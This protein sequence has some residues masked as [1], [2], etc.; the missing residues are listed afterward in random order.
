[1]QSE[2]ELNEIAK[3]AY[4]DFTDNYN[5]LVAKTGRT[6]FTIEEL[7]Y[8]NTTDDQTDKE[9]Q[10]IVKAFCQ[11]NNANITYDREGNIKRLNMD[12]VYMTPNEL[13]TWK[14]VAVNDCNSKNGFYGYAVATS[15]N[16]VVLSFRGS[17]A[18]DKKQ[19]LYDWIINDSG[20]AIETP[21]KLT[22]QHQEGINWMNQLR[23]DGFFDKY[24]TISTTGHSLGGNLAEFITMYFFS[25]YYT[26]KFGQCAN[27]DGP[28]LNDLMMAYFMPMYEKMFGKIT[29]YEASTVGTIFHYGADEYMN[30]VDIDVDKSSLNN[31]PEPFREAIGETILHG[32]EYWKYSNDDNKS[33]QRGEPNKVSDSWGAFFDCIDALPEECKQS[34]FNGLC[35]LGTDIFMDD[36]NGGLSINFFSVAGYVLTLNFNTDLST[37]EKLIFNNQFIPEEFFEYLVLIDPL[38]NADYIIDIFLANCVELNLISQE[39]ANNI[40]KAFLGSSWQK[41]KVNF[42]AKYGIG[43]TYSNENPTINVDT[44]ALREYAGRIYNVNNR[45]SLLD[46]R[47]K[48]L[49][50]QVGIRGL[51]NLISADVLTGYSWRLTK[52]QYYLNNTADSFDAAENDIIDMFK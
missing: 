28:G 27:L 3:M 24:Q 29:S 11:A 39:N 15:E 40:M 48:N 12:G 26:D 51:W 49:Y 8:A 19:T 6:E 30:V 16:D 18:K 17:E 7:L 52:C 1:M 36:E 23:A 37:L 46:Q 42:N 32:Q 43:A 5:T 21:D 38:S 9:K 33:F 31:I 35:K 13:S 34:M 2:K 4:I 45:L 47:L 25:E 14:I 50:W 20:L 10:E 44:D 41:A 22:P